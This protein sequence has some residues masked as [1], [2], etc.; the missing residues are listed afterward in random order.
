MARKKKEKLAPA[1]GTELTPEQI[2][3]VVAEA[4]EELR[5]NPPTAGDYAAEVEKEKADRAELEREL[6]AIVE[7]NRAEFV[8]PEYPKASTMA[9]LLAEQFPQGAPRVAGGMAIALQ[10]ELRRRNRLTEK[11]Y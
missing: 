7:E 6:D 2:Q 1:A 5:A 11:G 3:A 8:K 9:E 10:R 4:I